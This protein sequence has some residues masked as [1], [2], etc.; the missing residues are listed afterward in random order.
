MA[1]KAKVKVIK[2]KTI[3]V[4]NSSYYGTKIYNSPM[5]AF[6]DGH[7]VVYE[8]TYAGRRELVVKVKGD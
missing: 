4:A 8:Y 5:A 1:K 7:N 3:Y 6:K 2:A